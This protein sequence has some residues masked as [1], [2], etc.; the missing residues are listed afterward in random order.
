MFSTF[1]NWFLDNWNDMSY[2]KHYIDD[3]FVWAG[4]SGYQICQLAFMRFLQLCK[5]LGVPVAHDKTWITFIGLE[6]DTESQQINVPPGKVKA[7]LKRL[8]ST[9]AK[10]SVTLK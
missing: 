9:L 6:I 2:T 8:K 5:F 7:A 1:L 4:P 3:D 10:N